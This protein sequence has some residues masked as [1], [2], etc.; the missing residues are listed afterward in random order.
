V[1]ELV[2]VSKRYGEVVALSDVSFTLGR[3]ELLT[4]LGPNGSGKTTLLKILGGLETPTGGE[5]LVDG[6]RVEGGNMDTLRRRATVVFQRTVLFRGSVRRNVEFG[7]RQLDLPGD[8]VDR[9]IEEVL[10]LVG[11][12]EIADRRA[13]SLS[14]GEQQR[15]SLARALALDRELLLLDEPT[16]NLDPESLAIV[17]E[18][19]SGLNRDRGTTVVIATHNL[20]QAEELSERLILLIGGRIVEEG[21]SDTFFH[22]P[23]PE[24][25]R[26]ARSENVFTGNSL[27]VDGVAQ[28]DIGA[29]VKVRA[30]FNREG[31][32]TIHVAPEDII[33]SLGVLESSARNSLRGRIVG[34][35]EMN[36]VVKLKID[37]GR[38]FTAQITRRSL[39]E[40]GLNV[41][42]EVYIT[43][44][45]SSVQAI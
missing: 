27:I 1:I 8:E 44:K 6:V 18:V 37:V 24:M 30:T 21:T 14:G 39:L 43:F 34:V 32:A 11:L 25:R 15:L 28:V 26:F 40:M 35:E 17:K 2:G 36:S 5:V 23:S 22:T 12:E 3:G 42:Q 33:V 31:R 13:R 45:A 9:R 10:E 7:L 41:G 19:I 20:I 4:V 16:A 38:T 29:G